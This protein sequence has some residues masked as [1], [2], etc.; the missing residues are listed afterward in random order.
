MGLKMG[1]KNGPKKWDLKAGRYSNLIQVLFLKPIFRTYFW[2]SFWA[3]FFGPIFRIFANVGCNSQ[4]VNY[5]C[6]WLRFAITSLGNANCVGRLECRWVCL[7][8]VDLKITTVYLTGF[9]LP[10]Q[11]CWSP[12]TTR[13]QHSSRKHFLGFGLVCHNAMFWCSQN[14]RCAC[15]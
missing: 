5:I 3:P 15:S 2:S 10:L 11:S 6:G 13:V 8:F 1:S 12:V 14:C 7:V 4:N 9:L